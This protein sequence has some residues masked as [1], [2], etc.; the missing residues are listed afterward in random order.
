MT[1]EGP[2]EQIYEKVRA[3]LVSANV[4]EEILAQEFDF[5]L[6]S[7]VPQLAQLLNEVDFEEHLSIEGD[8][9]FKES[10]RTS[11]KEFIRITS[12]TKVVDDLIL[13]IQSSSEVS[14][15]GSLPEEHVSSICRLALLLEWHIYCIRCDDE[16]TSSKADFFTLLQLILESLFAISTKHISRFWEYLELRIKLFKQHVFD[17]NITLHRIALLGLCN[18][19]TDKYYIRNSF[20]KLDS[21]VKDTFNDEFQ[22]R[23]RL[24]LATMLSFEDLTGLNTVSYTHLTLPTILRV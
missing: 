9:E 13:G 5:D 12:L 23:V 7:E 17:K 21:Y 2:I 10:V 3:F 18:G 11:S 4:G 20:G 6:C 15:V 1:L 22:A 8:E 16:A 14:E 19:L 24:Y